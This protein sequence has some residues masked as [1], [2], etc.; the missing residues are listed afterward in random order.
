[1][2]VLKTGIVK[3][4]SLFL[5]LICAALLLPQ[6]RAAA[7]GAGSYYGGDPDPETARRA[8][9]AFAFTK[10][11]T[12][13]GNEYS[14]IV[15]FDVNEDGRIAVG[16]T[17]MTETAHIGIYN[18]QFEFMYG[19]SF[20]IYGDY[21]LMWDGADLAVYSVRENMIFILNEEG[22]I[23]LK[24]G[25]DALDDVTVLYSGFQAAQHTVNGRTYRLSNG[26]GLF[27]LTAGSYSKLEVEENGEMR[28]LFD[29]SRAYRLR[30]V[31][32]ICA[33]AAC[34]AVCVISIVKRIRAAKEKGK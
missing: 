11:E 31:A 34:L 27:D 29:A 22:V 28:I 14:G 4:A 5:I 19:C 26:G 21:G 10:E 12:D 23:G 32:I 18:E 33:V 16:Y 30:T 8:V 15:C 17:R 1:M 24:T 2:N 3:Q 7:S 20:H 6:G 13:A 25:S 9:E